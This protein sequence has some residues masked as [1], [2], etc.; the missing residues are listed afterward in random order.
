MPGR[1]QRREII[2]GDVR[3][4]RCTAADEL[5]VEVIEPLGLSVTAAAKIPA[6]TCGT[7]P[8]NW[9]QTCPCRVA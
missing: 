9:L 3:P 4:A 6:G 8:G 7:T 2:E 1:G 5:G